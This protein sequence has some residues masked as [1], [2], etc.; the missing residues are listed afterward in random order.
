MIYGNGLFLFAA[1][2]NLPVR[3]AK[4]V[5]CLHVKLTSVFSMSTPS[6]LGF[7]ALLWIFSP[8]LSSVFL[9]FLGRFLFSMDF[10]DMLFLD[11]GRC[12]LAFLY[13]PLTSFSGIF[14][15]TFF[16][17]VAATFMN[18][19]WVGFLPCKFRCV[20]KGVACLAGFPVCGILGYHGDTDSFRKKGLV[21]LPAAL[22][23]RGLLSSILYIIPFCYNASLL[24]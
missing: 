20:F 8:P 15:A 7:S 19:Q 5:P 21:M 9:V 22:T 3:F 23:A 12:Y 11:F 14:F 1:K 16:Y 24:F 4:V 17:A 2:A 13:Q 10:S 18:I 6:V